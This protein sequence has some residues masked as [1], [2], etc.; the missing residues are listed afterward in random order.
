MSHLKSAAKTM[1]P[2]AVILCA[3]LALNSPTA[4]ATP[5]WRV[6]GVNVTAELSPSISVKEI[7]TGG[8]TIA[9]KIIGKSVEFNCT[10]LQPISVKLKPEGA[11]GFEAKLKFSG[12]V[13]K[14]NGSVS[15]A[16]EPTGGGTPGVFISTTLKGQLVEHEGAGLVRFEAATGETLATMETTAL[17]SIGEEVPILGKFTLKDSALA[18]ESE[19]HL[20]TAG[21]L[22]E[23][24]VISKTEEHK[25]TASG[26]IIAKLAGT[27]AGL[28]WSGT[29]SETPPTQELAWWVKG[30]EVNSTLKPLAAVKELEGGSAT[31][32]SKIGGTKVEVTCTSSQLSNMKLEVKGVIASGSTINF[33]GCTTKLNEKLSGVCEP[34]NK[35][36]E[37]GAISSNALKGSVVSSEG[38]SFAR[39]EPTTGETLAVI[40]TTKECAIGEKISLLGKV[41]FKDSSFGTEAETHLVSVGPQTEMWLTSKTE[42]HKVTIDGSGVV[43][44]ASTHTG[45][46]WSAKAPKTG[47]AWRVKGVNVTAE[48]SPSISVK[49]IE[50]GG[51]T[52]AAKIIGKSVEF[53]CTTLQPISVKLKP[54]GAIGFEAKLKFS[55]CVTKINGSVS[56]ACEPTGGGTPGVFISTTLKGQLVEHE[57]AGL[58][59]F[60]AAT[61]E[62]LATM[63]TTAL[64]SIG[65]EVPILGKFTLKDSALATESETHLFTAGPLTELWVISKTEEHKVTASGSIIAKLAGTHAGLLWSGTL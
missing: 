54:E 30:A 36:V 20:F 35:G 65:E 60:E 18:T 3:M 26:S 24:W 47:P 15:G 17:C 4:N 7:E 41:T 64:C 9:A 11:I 57:G 16:C 8:A 12:C 45:M 48:L 39:F 63:E 2:L 22:T 23:L 59:R 28:L 37:P 5:N 10:T 32:L 13:T 44:L 43:R 34:T 21:P 51:A 58:V 1:A 40:E 52:I 14:I 53:N 49:E 33:S 55:G 31:L 56:G 42:E 50:T 29:L 38:S 62:T 61:G 46:L 19:T 6:K 25:V 27:H